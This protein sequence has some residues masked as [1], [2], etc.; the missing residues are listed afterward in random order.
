MFLYYLQVRFTEL[1]YSIFSAKESTWYLA[2][3][4]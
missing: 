3:K 2:K 4:G 1:F